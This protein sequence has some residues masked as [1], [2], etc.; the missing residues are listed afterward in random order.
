MSFP[1]SATV[2]R[3]PSSP[4]SPSPLSDVPPG[5]SQDEES[6]LPPQILAPDASG[7]GPDQTLTS[8][9]NPY[10]EPSSSLSTSPLFDVPPGESQDEESPLPPQILAPDASGP[11]PHQTLTSLD[12]PLSNEEPSSSPPPSALGSTLA[13]TPAPSLV[14]ECHTVYSVLTFA[15]SSIYPV[16][17]VYVVVFLEDDENQ[18][19]LLQRTRDSWC[20]TLLPTYLWTTM[21]SWYLKVRCLN[22]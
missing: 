3:G 4:P 22:W 17:A 21:I 16:I 6:P 9:D 1:N 15:I 2:L 10:E 11:G 14:T 8:L 20:L 12:N 5:E 13:T 7:P 18:L 19:P